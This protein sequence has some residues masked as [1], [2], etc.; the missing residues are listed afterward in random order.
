MGYY[1]IALTINELSPNI[2]KFI[3]ALNIVMFEKVYHVCIPLPCN[4]YIQICNKLCKVVAVV[5]EPTH[6]YVFILLYT[7]YDT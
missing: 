1:K 4:V 5:P 6:L 2:S 7:L 3:K